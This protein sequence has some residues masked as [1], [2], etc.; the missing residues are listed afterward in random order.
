MLATPPR[1]A[2]N[3]SRKVAFGRNREGC[4][5]SLT[6][7]NP[8]DLDRVVTLVNDAYRGSSKT[9]GWTHET[10]LL[11][12]KR[13]DSASLRAMIEKGGSTILVMSDDRNLVG[14]VALQ[15]LDQRQWYLSMLAVD[16]DLQAGG[17]GKSI[18]AG[19]EKFAREHGAQQIKISVIN[20]RAPLIAWYERQGYIRTGAVEPFPYDDA[21]VGTP[22][23]TD[24]SL[25]TLT[26]S[27]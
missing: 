2:G 14:C 20:L 24:L 23:R 27:L 25:I 9:P 11:A 15:A 1:R 19:A 8:A 26:K 4:S 5:V 22:L 6:I 13:V 18:M 3:T 17:L 10:A 16:P 21:T 12:G 7:A